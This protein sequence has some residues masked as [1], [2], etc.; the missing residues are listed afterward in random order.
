M[1]SRPRWQSSPQPGARLHAAPAAG[2]LPVDLVGFLAKHA[3]GS[4]G[5]VVPGRSKLYP[6]DCPW[7]PSH[8]AR[9][10]CF[11]SADGRLGFRCCKT[12]AAFGWRDFRMFFEPDYGQADRE[13]VPD[14]ARR[15]GAGGR[16]FYGA[17]VPSVA[18]DDR[19][20]GHYGLAANSS[21]GRPH[22]GRSQMLQFFS[23][24]TPQRHWRNAFVA[25]AGITPYHS[26][27]GRSRPTQPGNGSGRVRWRCSFEVW[28][29]PGQVEPSDGRAAKGDLG[30]RDPIFNGNAPRSGDRRP[31]FRRS[32]STRES[33]TNGCW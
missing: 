6:G 27:R 16:R 4:R 1:H 10:G 5:P 17:P 28:T 11:E 7:D 15:S 30:V 18:G 26:V 25:R 19:R 13:W 22:T 31:S 2:F 33:L 24:S 8:G 3:C 32:A 21:A 9:C 12:A 20:E 29:R 23:W 14:P